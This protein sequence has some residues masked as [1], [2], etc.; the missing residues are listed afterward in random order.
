MQDKE[1]YRHLLG[2]VHPW[3][4]AKVDL[5]ITKQRVDVCVEHDKGLRWPCPECGQ[6]HPLYDHSEERVWRHL[7]S[8]QFMTYLHAA[9][10]R[11]NCPDHGVKQVRLPWAD[12]KSRFTLLFECFAIKVLLHTDIKGAAEILRISWDEAMHIM[13]RAVSRG[14]AAKQETVINHLGVD[15]KAIAKGQTYL[16]ITCD[17]DRGVVD[18]IV[19]GRTKEALDGY[20]TALKENQRKG[21]EAVAIDMWEPFIQSVS[22]NLGKEKIVFDLFHI[23]KHMNEAVDIVRR[24]EHKALLAANDNTLVKSKYLWLYGKE[25]LPEK[26]CEHFESLKRLNLKTGRAWAIKESLRGIWSYTRLRWAK[27]YWKR[28]YYWATHSRLQPVIKVAKMLMRHIDNILTYFKYRITNAVSE[29][30]NAKIQAI[31]KQSYGF[32]NVEHFKIAIYF[33]CGGL[34]LFPS[35]HANV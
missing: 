4:V 3:T 11:V 17:L 35:T 2:L 12:A 29:G 20:F 24:R 34:Q 9:P 13:K 32:R 10:P 1:L 15:E 5:D 23:M 28:W 7:D 22:A 33:H 27:W 26:H 18:G 16:T 21:I 25:N 30:L 19:D 31:K 6:E 14:Q 8:C